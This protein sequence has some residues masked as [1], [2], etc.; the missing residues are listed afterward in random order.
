MY[1][2]TKDYFRYILL[3]CCPNKVCFEPLNEGRCMLRFLLKCHKECTCKGL[4][5]NNLE[6][7]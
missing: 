2:T 4:P 7:K 5:M 1:I 6:E 3:T